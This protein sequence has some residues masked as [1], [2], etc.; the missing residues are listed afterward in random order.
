MAYPFII[1]IF[2]L[3]FK[4]LTS[5]HVSSFSLILNEKHNLWIL[6]Q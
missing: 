2:G 4:C 3:E 1:N 5:N 6:Q